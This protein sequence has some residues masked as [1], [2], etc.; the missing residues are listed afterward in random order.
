M[1]NPKVQKKDDKDGFVVEEYDIGTRYEG[2]KK[3]GMRN[4]QGQFIYK[5]GSKYRGEWKDNKMEG[6]G[7]LYYPNG[8]IAYEG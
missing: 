6:Y 7:T 3:N 8:A 4:G 1:S 2:F 5:E